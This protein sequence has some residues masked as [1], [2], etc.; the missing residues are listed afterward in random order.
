VRRKMHTLTGN[1]YPTF[2]SSEEDSC[3]DGDVESSSMKVSLPAPDGISRLSIDNI[4]KSLLRVQQDNVPRDKISSMVCPLLS[5]YGFTAAN[6]HDASQ[7]FDS[8]FT[9]KYKH[10]LTW[11]PEHLGK[12]ARMLKRGSK[13]LGV[14]A[15][16]SRP[17][18]H[19][20]KMISA[21]TFESGKVSGADT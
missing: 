16:P 20:D 11:S 2:L 10:G 19:I 4:N 6:I 9:V 1:V 18:A 13:R 14:G 17:A 5:G 8:G 21:S 7:F 15:V 12:Y 3:S